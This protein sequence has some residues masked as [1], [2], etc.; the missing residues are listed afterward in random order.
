MAR[1]KS[2]EPKEEPDQE[3]TT[4]A[5][6]TEDS[7]GT[8]ED[9]TDCPGHAEGLDGEGGSDPGWDTAADEGEPEFGAPPA[10]N[11][12]PYAPAD[13]PPDD[14]APF[15]D[16]SEEAEIFQGDSPPNRLEAGSEEPAMAVSDGEEYSSLLQE[17][18]SRA[19]AEEL[20]LP[21]TDEDAIAQDE[22]SGSFPPPGPSGEA[23]EEGPAPDP[24][25]PG[26][27]RTVSRPRS[28]VSQRGSQVL[29][30]NARDHV[31]TE[32]E[33]EEIIWHEIR[34][35]Y[36]TRHMLAGT[37]DGLERTP[38]GKTLAVVD[39]KGFRVAIPL[40][41]MLFMP[42]A[43]RIPSGADY[44]AYLDRLNRNLTNML[45]AE[46][47]FIVK[48]I[49]S[50]THSIVA[51]RKDAMLRKR[52]IFYMNTDEL[53][54]HMI[55]EGRVVEARII[56]VAEKVV[57]VEVFG[58][59][60]AI[61]ARD[62]SWE[63][64]GDAR[65]HF[66]VGDRKPVRVLTID[67]SSLED[68]SITA[69]FRSVSATTNVD[70]VKRCQRQCRYVGRVT[71]VRSGVVYIRLNNGVNAIAHACYDIRTPGK[72]DDVSFAVTQ[73]DEEKGIA[74]GIITRIIKQNL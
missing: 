60:C 28:V 66:H 58:V 31:Q 26:N 34:N 32:Q 16:A 63:W 9:G 74:I 33:R 5:E 8:P 17:V 24:E 35:A 15:A 4:P 59:E 73:L 62:L 7:V 46:I 10:D 52:Q 42:N 6:S 72:K 70:N 47:D 3:I 19:P 50:N 11:D 2:V 40:K 44:V 43:S 48:G 30:I 56:A 25:R 20:S 65:E 49:D 21:L 67:R 41:E 27:A 55:Y 23:A 18:G 22:D 12:A 38:S 39:Y 29:T 37:L 69:D 54:S 14:A 53:G 36:R 13:F 1:K 61:V 57:R 45:G 64:L 68:M 51:S 71:D